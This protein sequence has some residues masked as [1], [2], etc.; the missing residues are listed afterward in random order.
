MDERKYSLYIVSTPIGN[1]NDITLRAL[2]CLKNVDFILC[3]DTRQSMKLLSHFEIS[4]PLISY[5]KFNESK[6][7]DDII[8]RLRLGESAAL[9]SDAG[10]PLI[11][12]PGHILVRKI[13]E[14]DISFCVLPGANAA[15]PSII[16]SGFSTEKFIFIG[17]FPKHKTE[18]ETLLKKYLYYDVPVISYAS[19]HELI[20]LLGEIDKIN[21]NVELCVN[22]ELTK[23]HEESFYGNAN[24]ILSQLPKEPKGE[25]TVVINAY[26]QNESPNEEINIEEMFAQLISNGNTK[27]EALKIISKQTDIPKK[28]LYN[29]FMIKEDK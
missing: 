10:T 18:R 19:P 2:E 11:S 8:D 5:H 29:R 24:E 9:I 1:L 3:E 26:S 15:L 17:F 14:N 23:L 13:I 12:D 27:N 4:K 25:F 16:K 21:P 20:K 6:T 22:K 7:C 28:E